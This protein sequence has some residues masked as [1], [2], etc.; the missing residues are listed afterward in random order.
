M[1]K[2]REMLP[3][4][5]SRRNPDTKQEY[6]PVESRDGNNQGSL[7]NTVIENAPAL[8]DLASDNL[9]RIISLASD[10]V[11]IFS[12]EVNT[13]STLAI[14]RENRELLQA[15]AE[16]FIKKEWARRE[17]QKGLHQDISNILRDLTSALEHGGH[18]DEVKKELIRTFDNTIERL[19]SSS[20]RLKGE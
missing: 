18:S 10:I 8:I 9:P 17:T 13:E 14:M 19:V 2:E 7:K 4:V 20:N 5:V 3:L 1:G 12:I 6:Y 15:E 11:E 16:A